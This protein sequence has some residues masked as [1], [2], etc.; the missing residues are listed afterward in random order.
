MQGCNSL[1][2]RYA[3]HNLSHELN[4]DIRGSLA[5][6][7]TFSA[8]DTPVNVPSAG[9]LSIAVHSSSTPLTK[10]SDTTPLQVDPGDM[11]VAGA[12]GCFCI[13]LQHLYDVFFR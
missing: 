10:L 3:H 1:S 7:T 13:D 2:K 11:H 12:L 6:A 4:N 8:V 5:V 9:G